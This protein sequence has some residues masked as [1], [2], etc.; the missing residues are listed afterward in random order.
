[1]H[2]S[3]RELVKIFNNKLP[4]IF[5]FAVMD[6]SFIG[7]FISA[8][9]KHKNISLSIL[10][11]L[12]SVKNIFRL[13]TDMPFAIMVNRYGWLVSFLTSR[14]SRI[15]SVLL[16]LA[17]DNVYLIGC[18]MALY[19][20]SMSSFYN[21]ID[22]YILSYTKQKGTINGKKAVSMYFIIANMMLLMCGT[23]SAY[24][25]IK[26][27]YKGLCLITVLIS[28]LSTTM[29]TKM[30]DIKME[31]RKESSQSIIKAIYNGAQVIQK[32]P[33]SLRIVFGLFVVQILLWKSNNMLNILL[34]KNNIKPENIA[35]I[36]SIH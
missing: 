17:C 33:K 9:I 8:F 32:H 27:G 2:N 21:K 22:T 35:I 36:T 7:P 25:Y 28:T 19:G 16:L 31:P 14:V 5:L 18:S 20:I 11:I 6:I 10:S 34:L 13:V 24:L 1:M 30:P 15:I 26:I 12:T 23:L 29:L 4:I 3:R